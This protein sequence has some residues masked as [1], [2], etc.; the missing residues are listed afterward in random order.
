[1][2]GAIATGPKGKTVKPSMALTLY[3]PQ[4]F[5]AIMADDPMDIDMVEIPNAPKWLRSLY[6]RLRQTEEDIRNLSLAGSL[7]KV[8]QGDLQHL[9]DQYQV[10]ADAMTQIHHDAQQK[11]D[12]EKSLNEAKL[13][14]I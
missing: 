2:S 12:I 5:D 7:D 9:K 1:M 4:S 14:Q 3:R 13:L 11:I 6:D 8:Q 10:L